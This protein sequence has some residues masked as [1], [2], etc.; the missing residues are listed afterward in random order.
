MTE[1]DPR[2]HGRVAVVPLFYGRSDVAAGCLRSLVRARA[3]RA[4]DIFAIENPSHRSGPV[5]DI[6]RQA[7]AA[8]DVAAAYF[9]AHNAVFNS[10]L[11]ALHDDLFKI[12]G[13]YDYIVLS[14][15]DIEVP[16]DFLDE[17]IGLLELNPNIASVA[18]RLDI[19]N[20]RPAAKGFDAA[21][22]YAAAVLKAERDG[23]TFIEYGSGLWM[24]MFRAQDLY[25]AL[26]C[27]VRNGIR[28]RDSQIDRY[29]Q[30]YGRVPACTMHARGR[31]LRKGAELPA[32]PDEDGAGRPPPTWDA[33]FQSSWNNDIQPG[34]VVEW[35]GRVVPVGADSPALAVACSPEEPAEFADAPALRDWRKPAPQTGV[36]VTDL[37]PG[38]PY[39]GVVLTLSRQMKRMFVSGGGDYAVIPVAIA[40]QMK[41]PVPMLRQ[42]VWSVQDGHCSPKQIQRVMSAAASLTPGPGELVVETIDWRR[43]GARVARSTG[44]LERAALL[45]S[46]RLPA[47]FRI[48]RAQEAAAP[49][50][51]SLP[52]L[53]ELLLAGRREGWT[54]T[55]IERP[56]GRP[57]RVRYVLSRA[58]PASW[59][60][61][62]MSWLRRD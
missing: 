29:F 17:Q 36:V 49:A 7:M 54:L 46:L 18:L 35:P 33:P 19:T 34:G 55:R 10:M 11:C 45:R 21:V 39:D 48:H 28:F 23:R 56:R 1:A 38:A 47:K 51:A 5:R 31:D 4:F 60:D 20:W 24:R 6:L 2:P 32:E 14:D 58:A 9:P 3:S 50:R 26:G 37:D 12:R 61:R 41:T 62:A 15:G 57:D 59:R 8:G 16:E 13:Q 22:H 43:T 30:I 40:A 42:V 25:P 27:L 53:A 44:R 52:D